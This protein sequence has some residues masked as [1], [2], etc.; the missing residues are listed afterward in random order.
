MRARDDVRRDHSNG[1]WQ[2]RDYQR[3]TGRLCGAFGHAADSAAGQAVAAGQGALFDA[4]L[5][6]WMPVAT[7]RLAG[8]SSLPPLAAAARTVLVSTLPCAPPCAPSS[9]SPT[10]TV[11]EPLTPGSTPGSPRS[12]A[13]ADEAARA[14]GRLDQDRN[15]VL[16]SAELALAISQFFTSR[17]PGACGN[18]AFGHL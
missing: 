10:R 1:V 3:L 2:H 6:P 12:T 17:D 9:R 11:A 4:L 8:M 7:S 14:F 15:G 16:D 13:R 18:L 5:L